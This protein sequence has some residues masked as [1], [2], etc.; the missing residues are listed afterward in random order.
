MERHGQLCPE[1]AVNRDANLPPIILVVLFGREKRPT[2]FGTLHV[3]TRLQSH[4]EELASPIT[5]G[6]AEISTIS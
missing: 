4:A 2:R 1:Y 6:F 3:A 5:R